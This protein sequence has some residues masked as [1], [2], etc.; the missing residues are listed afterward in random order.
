MYRQVLELYATA[1]DY[2][3]KS[4]ESVIFFQIVQNKLH[5]AAHDNT[6]SEVIYLHVDSN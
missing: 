2:T 4:E 3:P 6:A 5:F 1:V